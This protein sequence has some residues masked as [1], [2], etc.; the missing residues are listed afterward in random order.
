[1]GPQI[2]SKILTSSDF[3]SV[4]QDSK[5]G[6]TR[7]WGK[8]L[9]A[10]VSRMKESLWCISRHYPF[11]QRQFSKRKKWTHTILTWAREEQSRSGRW[12]RVNFLPLSQPLAPSSLF[13][14]AYKKT[15][16]IS[17]VWNWTNENFPEF[18]VASIYLK[19]YLRLFKS[20]GLNQR[21][22]NCPFCFISGSQLLTCLTSTAS[23]SQD[24][25][26]SITPP[27]LPRPDHW[28]WLP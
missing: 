18:P 4:F 27:P 22:P 20:I 14:P 9:K 17:W 8:M 10:V 13:P 3:L 2:T 26:V 15:R 25:G 6:K 19:N 23:A 12:W 24:W 11:P 28:P 21:E 1:M 5:S 7:V 16:L